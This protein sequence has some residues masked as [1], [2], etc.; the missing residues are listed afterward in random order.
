MTITEIQNEI[1]EQFNELDDWMDKYAML[2][3]WGE[4][5]EPLDEKLK[6]PQHLIEGCQSRVWI[7]GCFSDGVLHLSADSD[8]LITKGIASLLLKALSGQTPQDILSTDLYMIEKIGLSQHL[9]PT[10]SNGLFS[11]VEKIKAMAQAYT[12]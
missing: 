3:E 7:V 11:M 10:R 4:E 9:S 6:T 2:I 12:F 5:L 8:A 1:I